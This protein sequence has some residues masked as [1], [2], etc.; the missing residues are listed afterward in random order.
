MKKKVFT[1][2]AVV[3][4]AVLLISNVTVVLSE[5]EK[6][7][8]HL[9]F[10]NSVLA[11]GSGTSNDGGDGGVFYTT[12]DHSYNCPPQTVTSTVYYYQETSQVVKTVYSNGQ[13]VLGA[14]STQVSTGS[15]TTAPT[16]LP[17]FTSHW[18]ECL[19]TLGLGCTPCTPIIACSLGC[20]S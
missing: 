2:L 18:V 16:T 5:K 1:A 10:T 8:L 11:D 17:G 12:V 7:N 14:Y 4:T 13:I 9:G 15:Y 20:D 3:A 19:K 6:P